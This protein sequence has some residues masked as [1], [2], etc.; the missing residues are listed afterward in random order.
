MCTP[1]YSS[2][3]QLISRPLV[4][5]DRCYTNKQ[6][7]LTQLDRFPREQLYCLCKSQLRLVSTYNFLRLKLATQSMQLEYASFLA[8]HNVECKPNA[9]KTFYLMMKLWS[10]VIS[11]LPALSTHACKSSHTIAFVWLLLCRLLQLLISQHTMAALPYHATYAL[12]I[13]TTSDSNT[14]TDF[15]DS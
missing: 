6:S 8:E 15:Y 13:S 4:P 1:D 12:C 5:I 11:T 2:S 3:K 9:S 10:A 7:S 14:S